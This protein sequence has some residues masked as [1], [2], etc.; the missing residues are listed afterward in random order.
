M[1]GIE[2]NR[3]NFI[4]AIADAQ[5]R[6]RV[7]LELEARFVGCSVFEADDGSSAMFKIENDAPEV[8]LIDTNLPRLSGIKL[9]E[10]MVNR[11]LAP[12]MAIVLRGDVGNFESLT[13]EMIRGRIQL[14]GDT[15]S[16]EDMSR[17]MGRAL[18]F[19][20]LK[21]KNQAEF[22]VRYIAK[23]EILINEGEKMDTLYLVKRGKLL[24]YLQR[25]DKQVALGEASVGEFV[26][27]MAYINGEPRSANVRAAEDSEVIEIPANLIDHLIFLKPSWAKALL[28]TLSKRISRLNKKRN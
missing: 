20:T 21:T 7:R 3:R 15:D 5:Q 19:N 4:I 28:K 17:A 16:M 23:D 26:G 25:E 8:L 12:N 9:C 27:E 6:S 13:E 11:G 24:A 18:N 2:L 10:I 1:P 22:T 14:Y